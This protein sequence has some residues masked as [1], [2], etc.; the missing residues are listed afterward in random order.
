MPTIAIIS[1][2]GGAGKTT[3]ALHLAAAAQA[4]GRVALVVDTD[5]QATASQWAAWRQEAPPEVIDSPPPRLAAKIA[6]AKEQ[7]AEVIV[8]DTP[9]HADSAARAAV[10]AADLVLIPC[11]PSAFDLSAIQTTAKLVQLLR[12][13]AFVVFTAGPPNAPRIY[14]E[15]GELVDGFG[16]PPCPVLLPDRAAYRH[17]S[18]EGRTVMESEPAGKAA[19][20]VR[21]LYKWTCR[22]LDMAAP[23]F[24]KVAS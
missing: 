11:R 13:P 23:R 6:A 2:K 24:K 8:I 18:A 16:T 15:A 9:P 3:L 7:G 10:E 4:S 17:A 19:E 22:Q 20:E 14:Q 1:Q 12:R 5:P 21:E